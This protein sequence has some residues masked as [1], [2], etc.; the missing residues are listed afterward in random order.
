VLEELQV[1]LISARAKPH[2]NQLVCNHDYHKNACLVGEPL[3]DV[4]TDAQGRWPALIG[5][6]APALHLTARDPWMEW[7][8]EQRERRLSVR[9]QNSRFVIL[10]DRQRYPNWA[11]RATS[12]CL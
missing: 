12:V 3:R 9:A 1:G 7:S 11:S 8:E 4:V 10:A 6:S 2:W 5:W